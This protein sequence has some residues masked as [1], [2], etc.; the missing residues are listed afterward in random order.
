MVAEGGLNDLRLFDASGRPVPY[1]LVQRRQEPGWRDGRILPVA[2]TKT[3]SGFEVDFGTASTIDRVRVAGISGPFL[4]RLTLEGSGDRAH[5]TLL[6]GEGTLFNLPD[7]RI[8]NED[9]SFQP[10]AYR[11]V[12]VLWNDANS[13]RVPLPAHVFAREAG[14]LRADLRDLHRR[15]RSSDDRASRAAAA[16]VFSCQARGCRSSR[17]SSTLRPATCFVPC[18]CSSPV[19]PAPRLRLSSSAAARSCACFVLAR[20]PSPCA[21]GLRRPRKRSSI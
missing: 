17:S 21:S 16:I 2:A 3:T 10:G 8:S 15:C 6:Q 20:L 11:Y 14:G 4:K 1:L 9:L 7:E 5:W 19:S 18:R 13:G 12:R